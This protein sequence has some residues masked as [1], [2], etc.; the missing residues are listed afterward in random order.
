MS[1]TTLTQGGKHKAMTWLGGQTRKKLWT[2]KNIDR[3]IEYFKELYLLILFKKMLRL[4][5]PLNLS[6]LQDLCS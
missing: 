2:G 1:W 5:D 6:H 4:L 3:C